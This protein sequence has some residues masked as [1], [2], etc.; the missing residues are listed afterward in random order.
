LCF[1]HELDGALSRTYIAEDQYRALDDAAVVANGGG[2]LVDPPLSTISSNKEGVIGQANCDAV[3]QDLCDGIDRGRA[4]VTILNMEDI[5]QLLAQN[6]SLLPAGQIFRDLI[7]GKNDAVGVGQNDGQAD[8]GDRS[9]DSIERN[10]LVGEQGSPLIDVEPG[11]A[12]GLLCGEGIGAFG[13][14]HEDGSGAG[15]AY[16]P[17]QTNEG[18]QA[19]EV[20]A[21]IE[22]PPPQAMPRGSREG[23]VVVVPSFSQSQ[24]A[25]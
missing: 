4:G 3:N 2:P 24:D 7:Q 11:R 21:D 19:D 9:K 18:E 5:G 23:M 25:K 13:C 12:T 16:L 10:F 8:F 22:L 6:L 15:Q 14:G 17:G 1:F 20:I